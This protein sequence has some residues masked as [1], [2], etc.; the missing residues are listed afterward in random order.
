[1][2]TD[3]IFEFLYSN[4]ANTTTQL[5][6]DSNSGTV[7]NIINPDTRIQYYSDGCNNDAVTVSLTVSFDATTT[8][9]RIALKEFNLKKFRIYYNGAT[10]NTFALTTTCATTSS[11][12]LTNSETS[13]FMRCTSVDCTSV[14]IDMYSTQVAN[15]E[16][17]IGYLALS[18]QLIAFERIP[19]AADY[20]PKIDP[21]Q[22]MHVMSDGGTRLHTVKEKYAIDIK[23]KHISRSF[24][25]DLKDV[26]EL[27]AP[28]MFAPFG[29]TTGWDTVL[30]ECVWPGNFDFHKFSDNA[31]S[32]G[33]SGSIQLR[34][35]SS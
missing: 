33:F 2:A 27:R 15:S 25:D 17:A 4:F 8:I 22:V 34:E 21:E 30:F 19:A 1:M 16:K 6:V 3:S 9:S 13:M 32:S 11:N 5:T 20:S 29:T 10:A 28:F 14:T 24:R 7:Q 26:Y 31:V 18:K 23:F 35:T 12:F